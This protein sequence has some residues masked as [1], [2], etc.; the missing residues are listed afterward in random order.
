MDPKKLGQNIRRL[1]TEAN[2]G[3]RALSRM[4]NISPAS[5]T[6][7]EKGDTS[8]TLATLHKVLK[9]LGTDFAGFFVSE[10]EPE[11]PVFAAGDM[12]SVSDA[13]RQYLFLLP[14]RQDV[15]FEMVHETISPT[16]IESEWEVRDCDIGGVMLSGGPA[17]L[18][19]E[20]SGQWMLRKG[21][22]F[23]IKAGA[24]HRLINLGKRVLTQITV[25][26]PPRY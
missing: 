5:L 2:I 14:K 6:A 10:K 17:R 12:Q 22:A 23:Y 1:R 16:E 3:L 24:K 26:D 7:I 19:I 9:A 4:A 13:N 18:E 25:M 21:D 15:K 20:E 11:N 8:P